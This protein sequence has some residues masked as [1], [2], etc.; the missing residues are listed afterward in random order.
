VLLGVYMYEIFIMHA[1][2]ELGIIGSFCIVG[3]DSMQCLF[4]QRDNLGR[5]P[6][7]VRL[8]VSICMKYISRMQGTSLEAKVAV[9]SS[10]A[11]SVFRTVEV[12]TVY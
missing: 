9:S 12:C 11:Y 7:G 5:M 6:L 1:T 2:Y 4:D 10:S 3:R 8:C